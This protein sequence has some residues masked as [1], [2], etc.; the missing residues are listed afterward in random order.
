MTVTAN[1][2][3][4]AVCRPSPAAREVKPGVVDLLATSIRQIGLIQPI[5]VRR[6]G[7]IYEVIAGMHRLTAFRQLGRDEI[8]AIVRTDGDLEAELALIDENL[9]R[10]DLSPAERAASIARRKVLY[11]TLHPE[12]THGGDRRSSRQV[13]DLKSAASSRF[14]AATAVATGLGER[15]IQREAARGEALGD[16]LAKIVGTVLDTGAEL[17]ALA[18]LPAERRAAVIERAVAGEKVSAKTEIKKAT[19]AE[20]EAVLG[21]RQAALPDRRYGVILADPEWRFEPWSRETGMDRAADNH[22]PTSC[23]DVITGRPVEMIAAADAV[24]FLWATVPML[25]HALLVMAAWGFDYVSHLVWHKDRIGTGYWCRNK[26]ELVLIGTRG[27]VPAPAPGENVSSMF[28]APVGVHSAKPDYVPELIERW[29]PSVPKIELNRRGPPRPGWDA[30]GNET[31]IVG[32]SDGSSSEIDP[33][34]GE[35]IESPAAGD[36]SGGSPPPPD[37]PGSASIVE[38]AHAVAGTGTTSQGGPGASGPA[39]PAQPADD[40]LDIPAFLRRPLKDAV[41]ATSGGV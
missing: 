35:I 25:P 28:D 16:D 7:A 18:R 36:E 19:R 40:E 8:P 17:D 20:R 2:I 5:V 21:A 23:L 32:A 31:E 13:G 12:A 27:S 30:W 10:A 9:I 14:T 11:E 33:D 15:T 37:E 39:R 26:H 34:A 41:P 6:S 29:Y 22:Y 4:V 1:N 38:V 24:L 3:P